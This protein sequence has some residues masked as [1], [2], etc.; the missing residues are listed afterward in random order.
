MTRTSANLSW[1]ARLALVAMWSYVQDNGVGKNNVGSIIGQLFGN[2]AETDYEATRLRVN[3][4]LDEL[5]AAGLIS[6]FEHEGVKYLEVA[7]WPTWQ[8]PDHPSRARFPTSASVNSNPREK[9][10]SISR[11]S[12]ESLARQSSSESESESESDSEAEAETFPRDTRERFASPP[13][14]ARRRSPSSMFKT[15]RRERI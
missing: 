7:N 9:A 10:A 4:A 5:C 1:D 15:S 11:D 8:R 14:S 13:E 12:R 2:D 3:G 6:R